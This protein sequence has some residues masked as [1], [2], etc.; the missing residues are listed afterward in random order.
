MTPSSSS[1]QLLLHK[2]LKPL[3]SKGG[4]RSLASQPGHPNTYFPKSDP[5]GDSGGWGQRRHSKAPGSRA[6]PRS[7]RSPPAPAPTLARCIL[8][9]GGNCCRLPHCAAEE[10]RTAGPGWQLLHVCWDPDVIVTGGS[11]PAPYPPALRARF[12]PKL[13]PFCSVSSPAQPP[14]VCVSPSPSR[15]FSVSLSGSPSHTRYKPL[16]TVPSQPV[17]GGLSPCVPLLRPVCL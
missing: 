15:I 16:L 6:T 8:G 9:T 11:A 1:V 10:N 12:Y 13:R 3:L 2:Y 17:A 7:S 14:P 4:P 5:T